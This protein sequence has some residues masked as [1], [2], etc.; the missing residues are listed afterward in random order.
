[1][2]DRAPQ[3]RVEGTAAVPGLGADVRL[4]EAAHRAAGLV[5]HGHVQRGDRPGVH[6]GC[7]A[8]ARHRLAEEAAGGVGDVLAAHG[9]WVVGVRRVVP[10]DRVVLAGERRARRVAEEGRVIGG[11]PPPWLG[12][13]AVAGSQEVVRRAA[14]D[15]EPERTAIPR[16]V[17]RVAAGDVETERSGHGLQPRGGAEALNR[18][19]DGDQ[20]ATGHGA[21][22][23]TT[24]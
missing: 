4:D 8:T 2:S 23:E 18:R 10:D 11:R 17:D 12:L 3:C 22:T 19:A 16:A 14:D 6:A 5:V 20:P 13:A 15:V 21:S 24:T 7:A 9:A 1:M